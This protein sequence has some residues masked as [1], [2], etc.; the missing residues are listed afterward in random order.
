MT[1]MLRDLHEMSEVDISTLVRQVMKALNV[2]RSGGGDLDLPLR[3]GF[4]SHE[5]QAG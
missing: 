5:V 2:S 1:E 3:V 4:E